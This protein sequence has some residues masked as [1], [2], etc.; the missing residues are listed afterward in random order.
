[1]YSRDDRVHERRRSARIRLRAVAALSLE[2]RRIAA[3]L[4]DASQGG[5][6]LCLEEEIQSGEGACSVSI[7]FGRDP[8]EAISAPIRV[9]HVAHR[10]VRVQWKEPLPPEDWI[11]LR[12]LIE[13]E[14]GVLT[15]VQ[16][17]LPML[18]WP[19]FLFRARSTRG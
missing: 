18:V 6:L 3:R 1:M 19:S 11:K 5:A 15:V 8:A 13:R 2:R 7:A 4:E 16:G 14:F 17:R 10:L 9:V 12:Q